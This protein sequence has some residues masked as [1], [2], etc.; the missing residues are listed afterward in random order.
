MK[1]KSSLV[2]KM[3]VLIYGVPTSAADCTEV[4][5]EVALVEAYARGGPQRANRQW[6]NQPVSSTRKPVSRKIFPRT[7]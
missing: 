6:T 3:D 1:K 7:R 5:A 2:W 4:L